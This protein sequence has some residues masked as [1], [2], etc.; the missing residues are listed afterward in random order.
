MVK[1]TTFTQILEG[2]EVVDYDERKTRIK[3]EDLIGATI[4]RY[5]HEIGCGELLIILKDGRKIHVLPRVDGED[6]DFNLYSEE[7]PA[8]VS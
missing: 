8:G 7:Q 2:G 3:K 6:L 5:S 1:L 4:D